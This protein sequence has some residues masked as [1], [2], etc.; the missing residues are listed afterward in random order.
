[1]SVAT[2]SAAA[3]TERAAS[4]DR[5]EAGLEPGGSTARSAAG[6]KSY[7]MPVGSG[8]VTGSGAAAAGEVTCRP[9]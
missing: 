3:A 2:A 9:G 5:P 1:M 4:G 8:G 7:R 6:K